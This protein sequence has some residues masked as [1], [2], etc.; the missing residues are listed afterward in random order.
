MWPLP[1]RWRLPARRSA[2]TGLRR[3]STGATVAPIAEPFV[4]PPGIS[5]PVSGPPCASQGRQAAVRPAWCWRSMRTSTTSSRPWMESC[6]G[7]PF[8]RRFD[9][10][11]AGMMRAR[12]RVLQLDNRRS[13]RCVVKLVSPL[14]LRWSRCRG[15]WW[16][17]AGATPSPLRDRDGC[18]PV[19]FRRYGSEPPWSPVRSL[20]V[21]A[22]LCRRGRHR[23]VGKRGS[24]LGRQS[25]RGSLSTS[26]SSRFLPESRCNRVRRRRRSDLQQR[27]RC[28]LRQRR[29]SPMLGHGEVAA[30]PARGS[31]AAPSRPRGRRSRRTPRAPPRPGGAPAR[32]GAGHL[33]SRAAAATPG[34]PARSSPDDASRRPR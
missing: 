31:S 13:G 22:V 6:S 23:V 1:V 26:R 3:D 2:A 21:V 12:T 15:R 34:S 5:V 7:E 16:W 17:A 19:L 30:V 18:L 9:L 4:P 28:L 14:V 32:R 20:R 11:P 33:P 25:T 27:S 24:R 29:G 10:W 8:R